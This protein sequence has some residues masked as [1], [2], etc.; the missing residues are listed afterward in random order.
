MSTGSQAGEKVRSF[1]L[2]KFP[3]AKARGV[4]DSDELLE[5]GIVDSLGILDVVAMLE[6]D[7][8]ILISDEDLVP[9]NFRSIEQIAQFAA[10][11]QNGIAH[12][13]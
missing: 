2:A 11:K 5:S 13:A 4:K 9:E 8:N 3:L 7:F 10:R 12:T 1:V 6:S